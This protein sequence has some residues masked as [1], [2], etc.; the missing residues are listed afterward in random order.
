MAGMNPFLLSD[1][2][3]VYAIRI[4][5]RF[6]EAIRRRPQPNA[7][8]YALM[9]EFSEVQWENCM[10]REEIK[11]RGLRARRLCVDDTAIISAIV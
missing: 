7:I 4:R 8:I 9:Q 2:D 3:L 5:M 10:I 6:I 11:R 1:R